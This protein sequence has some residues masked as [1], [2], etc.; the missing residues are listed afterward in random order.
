MKSNLSKLLN[1]YVALLLSFVFILLNKST[2]AQITP[3]CTAGNPTFAV[4][5]GLIPSGTWSSPN[6]SRNGQ[7]CGATNP[8]ECVFFYLY[9]NPKTVA[10]QIDM[11][12]ADPSG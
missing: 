8:D 6:I 9:L 2:Q 10:L 5:L 3:T 4:H 11:I 1:T 12:G 7:W